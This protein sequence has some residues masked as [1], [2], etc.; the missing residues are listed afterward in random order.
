M[1][2]GKRPYSEQRKTTD[3]RSFTG[4]ETS[5]ATLIRRSKT[6]GKRNE[7]NGNY[8]RGGGWSKL[9]DGFSRTVVGWES[10]CDEGESIGY[11]EGMK[12]WRLPL[13]E[14]EGAILVHNVVGE[15]GRRLLRKGRVLEDRHLDLLRALGRETVVVAR[16]EEGD[17]EED[18]AATRVAQAVARFDSKGEGGAEDVAPPSRLRL[19]RASTGRVNFYAETLGLLR[20]DVERLVALNHCSGITLATLGRGT[21]VQRGKMI[22]TL[23]VIPYAVP[24]AVVEHARGE[25]RRGSQPL[26]WIEPLPRRRVALVLNGSPGARERVVAGF[27]AALGSRLE[28]LGSELGSTDFV[29]TDGDDA[30]PLLVEAMRRRL[31]EG[32]DLLLVAGDTAIMDRHDIIPRA[33]VEAG[34]AVECFGVPVDPGNLLLLAYRE[35]VPILGTPGCSRSPKL[36]IVDLVLP[37]LLVGER[38]GRGDLVALGHGG[39]LDDVPERPL[40]R[41]RLG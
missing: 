29:A 13:E 15:D 41:S 7:Q 14:S 38:L 24:G 20:V 39:L 21:V 10:C 37:R 30:E 40:P 22:A 6:N 28:A 27:E 35:G 25:A 23:K 3:A 16:L 36:N 34:G 9:E 19:S 4:I 11:P 1:G 31:E 2:L 8:Y 18:E 33:V 26:L 5:T 17:V 32:C 12:L